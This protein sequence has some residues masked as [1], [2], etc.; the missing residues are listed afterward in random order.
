MIIG[1]ILCGGIIETT[2]FAMGLSVLI[3][4]LKRRHNTKKCKCR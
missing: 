2:L 4:W 3:S 1:C